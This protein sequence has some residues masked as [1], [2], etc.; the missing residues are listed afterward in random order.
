VE[1][2]RANLLRYRFGTIE[3]MANH[4]HVLEG[5]TLFFYR[6]E[7]LL[8]DGGAKVLVELALS[9]SEQVVTLRGAV[10]SRAS[11]TDGGQA[12]MWLEFPDARLAKLLDQGPTAL[13]NRKHKRLGC[14]LVIEVRQGRNPYLGRIVDVSMG[15]IRVV[16]AAQLHLRSEVELR[17]VSP[18][19]GMPAD[20]GRAQVMRSDRKSGESGLRFLREDRITRVASGKLFQMVQVGW[21]KVPEV[22]H[23]PLCCQG[24]HML[25][26]PLPHMKT[27]T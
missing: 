18:E 2:T 5:R 1:T 8:L 20:L 13:S 9:S 22:A 14:D 15:G 3:Q 21:N 25:E 11:T 10:L 12:G 4:L 26:P 17:L 24:G 7:R 16:G 6:H 19:E 27:R 23:P